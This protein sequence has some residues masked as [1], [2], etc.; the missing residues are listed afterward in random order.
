[1]HLAFSR[2]QGEKIYVTHLLEKNENAIW[3]VIEKKGGHIYI[4]G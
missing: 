3:N 4:C 1:M 2:E